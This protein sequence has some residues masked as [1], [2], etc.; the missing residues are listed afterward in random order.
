[1]SESSSE[2]LLQRWQPFDSRRLTTR[3]L[4]VD[5][6]VAG[7]FVVVAA[8]MPALLD[9]GRPFD[10]GIAAALIVS[11]ALASRVRLYVGAGAAV[12]TQ[13]VFVPMLFLLPPETVPACVA[14]ASLLTDTVE[15]L[16][17]TE[18]PDRLVAGIADCWY[19]IGA[20]L[21]FVIAGAPSAEPSDWLVLALALTA[22]CA[23][24]LT[25]A[26]V[27]EWL[28]RG[29]APAVQLRVIAS[30]FLV[31]ACLAPI[32]LLIAM[33]CAGRPFAVLLVLPLLAVLAALAVDRRRR[34]REAVKRLA[35]LEDQHDR[36]DR[37]IH[38]IGEAFG[39]KLDRAALADIVVRTTVEAVGARYG[40]ATLASV[41]IDH[42]DEPG[43]AVTIAEQAA[44]R[45]GELRTAARDG[46]FA[47]AQPL[48]GGALAASTEVLSVARTGE[49]FTADEEA[50]FAYLARQ[51]AVAL[52]NVA[53]H[54]QLRR[55]AT[56]DEVTG[57]SNHRR[58]QEA[59]AHEVM[60]MQRSGR[61][62]A[63]ALID[64]DDFKQINDTHGH[65]HG[66]AVLQLVADTLTNV[67]RA[68][69]EPARYGG[70]ELAVILA[71]TDIE[72]ATTIAEDIR[73]T[74]DGS[75]VTVSVGV[76]AIE[77]GHGDVDALIEAADVGLYAA[78]R[79][80]K[81]RVRSGGWATARPEGAAHS[82]FART[83]TRE[84][85]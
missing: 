55:Q 82:R 24:D 77:P 69:D 42:G 27:R 36:L 64:I 40:R 52:E 45:A 39:S 58:F 14:A 84:R 75:G 16:R 71:E 49:P 83:K 60:R 44:R 18:H 7:A 54:D 50:L 17:R 3:E 2:G 4:R 48:T 30:V 81:N 34:I 22:Q 53:L 23:V 9:S 65:R 67:C 62:T 8:L 57:L 31:D 73:R 19:S 74:L 11:L 43:P 6:L 20:S 37:A 25:T 47:M 10:P 59:L 15:V 5:A 12:P 56:V 21:V 66:D 61:P 33:A 70:D 80:G 63:L 29:I 51:T 78:K 32:G 1:V 35:Q 13:L 46:D 68:T 41:A 72:G 76:A 79:T 26:T 85:A 28:G 38:R